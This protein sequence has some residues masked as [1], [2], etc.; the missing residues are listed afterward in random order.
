[1]TLPKAGQHYSR[2]DGSRVRVDSVGNGQVYYVAWRP[3]QDVGNP[4]RMIIT[5]F[6]IEIRK[7]GMAPCDTYRCASCGGRF[8]L[9]ETHHG[10]HMIDTP[11]GSVECGRVEINRP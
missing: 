7:E 6:E 8:L 11:K 10:S 4:I 5:D 1:M 2:P 9:E 3:G